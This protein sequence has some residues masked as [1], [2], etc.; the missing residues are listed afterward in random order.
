MPLEIA[1]LEQT[2]LT[3]A[4]LLRLQLLEMR[5]KGGQS[6]PLYMRGVGRLEAI[7]WVMGNEKGPKSLMFDNKEIQSNEA[8]WGMF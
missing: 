7:M 8:F 1:R 2:M 4:E 5:A 3:Q 6:N